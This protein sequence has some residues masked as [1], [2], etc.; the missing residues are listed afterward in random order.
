VN[1]LTAG[2]AKNKKRSKNDAR[3]LFSR[4][5]AWTGVIQKYVNK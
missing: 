4:A 5:R 2:T 1:V 3:F